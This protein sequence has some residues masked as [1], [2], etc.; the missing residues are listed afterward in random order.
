MGKIGDLF[1][2]LG[3]KSDDF[4]KGMA[5]AKKESQ[6]FGR[7]LSNMKAGALA[8]WA[9]IGT[10]V[11]KFGQEMIQT[12]NVIGDAWGRT[13]AAMT[14]GWKT[15]VQ[16]LSN[17]DFH[18]FIGKFKEVTA[19]AVNLQN[20][21]DA[22][23][24]GTNSIK[25]QRAL[26]ADDL[27]QL[28]I[29]MRDQTKSQKE[30]LA[31]AEEYLRKVRPIYEQEIQL[32]NDLLDAQQ[33]KW[34]AGTGLS[35][36]DATRNDLMKFLVDY[37]KDKKLAEQIARYV[38]LEGTNWA[39]LAASWAHKPKS[40]AY[41]TASANARE[42]MQLTAWLKNYGN[43][44]GY[45]NFI[46]TFGKIYEKWRGDADTQPLVDAIVGAGN[47]KA[48]L[49]AQT[50]QIQNIINALRA[51]LQE[52]EYN[53]IEM[54]LPQLGGI[55]SSL[56]SIEAPDIF[57]KQWLERQIE[58]GKAFG[59]QQMALYADIAAQNQML[60]QSFISAFSG[61]MQAFTD[62]LFGIEGAG[63]EQILAAL[64]QPFAQTA[65]QLGEMLIAQ[66]IAIGA[67]KDSL[68]TLQPGVAIA[69][70]MALL[71]VGA[72]LS[73]GIKKLGG[74]GGGTAAYTS[75]QGTSSSAGGIDTYQQEITVHVVGEISGDKIVL[76]G[77]KTLNKW[78]R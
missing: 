46:G 37:G 50:R 21:L 65:T 75:A 31:A 72:A 71:A 38:E 36:N 56:P 58:N 30:R 35:D 42:M 48:G 34:L 23:F 27:E 51:Q 4:K 18:G 78:N 26:M 44:A 57:S 64:L 43:Q 49:N 14:A 2:R 25:I 63:A 20:A 29:A 53:P 8:V 40:K 24:E 32:A 70:G 16:A 17:F 22:Q 41:K 45:S 54:G 62:M 33:G 13:T 12:T 7:T 76:A 60:E 1:V 77:Q 59:E 10:A 6:S 47:A 39:T 61:G 55:G 68:K 3:L 19:A 73:S 28:R 52:E 9:A 11:I 69:A 5:D 67:F 66:G 74:S 15:F